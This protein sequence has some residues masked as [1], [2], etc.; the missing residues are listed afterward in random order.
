MEPITV[1]LIAIVLTLIAYAV[2]QANEI[3]KF[4]SKLGIPHKK[5]LLFFGNSFNAVLMRK[6]FAENQLDVLKDFQNEPIVGFYDLLKPI[7]LIKDVDYIEKVLVKDFM[8]FMDRGFPVDKR[9]AFDISLFSMNGKEWRALRYKLSP[10]FTTT[11]LKTMYGPMA[12]CSQSLTSILDKF[13]EKEDVDLKDYLGRFAMDVIGSC[14]YG[15][16]AKNLSEPDNEFRRMGKKSFEFDKTQMFKFALINCAPKLAKFFRLSF[17]KPDVAEYFCNIIRDTIDYRR[18]HHIVRNDFLQMFMT[19]KDKG[20]LEL[21]INDPDDDYLQTDASY[22][23]ENIEFTDDMMIGNAFT[24]LNAGFEATAANSLLTIY[25]LSKNKEIQDKARQEILKYVEEAGGKLTYE[26]L[27]KMTYL[28]Q[29]VK[30]TLRKYP[31]VPGLMRVC[32]KEYTLPN[33]Y[34][35]PVGQTVMIPV[36]AVHKDPQIYPEPEEFRPERF[37]P[38]QKIP[39]CAFLPFGNGPRICIAMRFALLEIKHCT[40]KLLMNHEFKLSPN[41]K[42]FTISKKSFFMTPATPLL[43]NIKKISNLAM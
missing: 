37:D 10:L 21:R 17:T 15:I 40:A 41:T 18:E 36:A 35:I 12:D 43:F 33:G 34:K 19:L 27:R 38:D 8:Y 6:H 28:E 26:A 24:F 42:P 32:N 14:A 20:N 11:K 29:C 4:W 13:S 2:Y 30:E 5:P 3:N 1:A 16:D 23:V 9:N 39:S 25:E 7:L 22:S 31:P